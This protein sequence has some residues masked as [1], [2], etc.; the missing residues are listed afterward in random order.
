GRRSAPKTM[1][2]GCTKRRFITFYRWPVKP[3][4]LREKATTPYR[5]RYCGETRMQSDGNMPDSFEGHITLYRR[6]SMRSEQLSGAARIAAAAA[7]C[8]TGEIQ[9]TSLSPGA[10]P[11][12]RWWGA[13]EASFFHH[14]HG[15]RSGQNGHL[16][17][18]LRGA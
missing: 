7:A 10:R 4:A 1:R 3:A 6:G 12:G 13:H 17:T 8:A 11:R 5:V 14:G 15:C 18:A 2:K 16:G 9:P